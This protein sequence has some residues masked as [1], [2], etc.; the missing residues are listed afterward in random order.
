[1]EKELLKDSDLG[2]S[3]ARFKQ[4]CGFEYQRNRFGPVECGQVVESYRRMGW[5][6]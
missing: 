4:V 3:G 5:W 6:P 2:M 1:M